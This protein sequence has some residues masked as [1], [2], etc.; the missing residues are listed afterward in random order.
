MLELDNPFW[1]FSLEVYSAPGVKDECLALQDGLGLDVNVVLFAAW[2][3][4]ERAVTI[5]TAEIADIAALIGDWSTAVVQPLRQARRHLKPYRDA[6]ADPRIRLARSVAGVELEAERI[7]QA[8][9]YRWSKERWDSAAP[10]SVEAART[11]ILAVMSEPAG[12][13]RALGADIS[14]SH[15]LLAV[16]ARSGGSAADQPAGDGHR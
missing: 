3:G 8:L 13:G 12:N 11:N 7:E 2:L 16:T 10:G 14:I 5:G 4:A 15:L 9:L 6:A 1:R